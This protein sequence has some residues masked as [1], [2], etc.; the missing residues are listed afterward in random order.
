MDQNK[1]TIV[2]GLPRSGTSLMMNMLA[3]GG[4]EPLTDSIRVADEDNPRGYYEL[5]KVKQL[6]KDSSWLRGARGKTVK[7]ISA[8]L[9]HLPAEHQYNVIFMRRKMEE[10]LASQRQM[11]IRRGQPSESVSD[12]RMAE[13]FLKHLK[14]VEAWLSKQPNFRV[15]YVSYNEV[16]KEPLPACESICGFL[17]AALDT[18]SMAEAVDL[19]LYR[20][21]R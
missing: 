14:E 19:S 11:L 8:L 6:E 17:E 4:L 15:L 21:Q 18:K 20:Q 16:I 2:S 9:R 7:I 1:I 5:E 3:L 10:L 13:M 12:E